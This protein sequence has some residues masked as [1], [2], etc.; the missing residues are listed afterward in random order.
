MDRIKLLF[1]SGKRGSINHFIPLI[2]ELSKFKIFNLN[3][4]LSDMHLSKE[5][6]LTHRNYKNL[7]IKILKS[8]SIRQNYMGTKFERA[9]SL[10]VGMKKNIKLLKEIKPDL[11]IILGDRA[12]LFSIAVPALILNIPI[13]HFY[14]GD[15]T[16]GC[17]DEPTRH[18]ISM[19]SNF[20]FGIWF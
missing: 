18:S 3:L 4:L 9:L 14:G 1:F 7:K 20:H 19:I 11:L 13:A 2:K 5:F 17:T 15:I 6:G 16:Q 8:I 12:E 10:S